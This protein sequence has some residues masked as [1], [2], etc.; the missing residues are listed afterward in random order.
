MNR[1]KKI[2]VCLAVL[3]VL[4]WLGTGVYFMHKIQVRQGVTTIPSVPVDA[5]TDD[6][7]IHGMLRV[8]DRNRFA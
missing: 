7:G 3:A 1:N 4:C 6:A 8:T 5:D 2:L